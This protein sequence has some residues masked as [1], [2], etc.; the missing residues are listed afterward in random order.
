MLS[1]RNQ[2]LARRLEKMLISHNTFWVSQREVCV[3]SVISSEL[4]LCCLHYF[5]KSMDNKSKNINV[6]LAFANLRRTLFISLVEASVAKKLSRSE[7]SISLTKK[8]LL[9]NFPVLFIF[10]TNF[11]SQ[12]KTSYKYLGKIILNVILYRNYFYFGAFLFMKQLIPTSC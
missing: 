2:P 9:L 8:T 3:K 4:A 1:E 10:A 5:S 11:N 7:L 12:I 6:M